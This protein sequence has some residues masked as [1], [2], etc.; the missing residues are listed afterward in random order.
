MVSDIWFAC[1]E[2]FRKAP[3]FG[4]YFEV[5]SH[6]SAGREIELEIG[7]LALVFNIVDVVRHSEDEVVGDEHCAAVD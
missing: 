6:K 3:A 2:L 5:L 1:F 4:L 7:I